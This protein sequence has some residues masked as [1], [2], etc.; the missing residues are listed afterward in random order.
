MGFGVS[1][2]G[3]IRVKFTVD[4]L[5]LSKYPHELK[6]ALQKIVCTTCKEMTVVMVKCLME[7]KM[8][9][10]DKRKNEDMSQPPRKEEPTL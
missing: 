6:Q 8:L 3:G 7:K 10:H 9:S 4:V 5:S 2:G 1:I